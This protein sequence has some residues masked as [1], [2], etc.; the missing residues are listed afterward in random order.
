MNTKHI[1]GITAVAIVISTCI[2]FGQ[3]KP[4]TKK[5]AEEPLTKLVEKHFAQW[6]RN[7]NDV[8]DLMEVDH[9]IEDHNVH[10]RQ[11]AFVVSLRRHITGENNPAT[12]AHK[13]VLK[14]ADDRDFIKSV[15]RLAK[16][17]DLI[18]RE[19]FLAKDP[20][21][22]TFNQGKLNDCYY[23][24]PVAAL[25][26][27]SPKTIRSMIHPEV[28]GGFQVVYGDGQKIHVSPLTEGELLLGARLNEKH[29]SWLAVLEKSY[30]VIRKR[31]RAK[32][33][34]KPGNETGSEV[35]ATLNWGDSNPI[36]ALLTGHHAESVKLDKN[37]TNEKLH[38]LLTE[39][40]QK[41][42]LMC[43]G[44]NKD[45]G[46]P[47]IATNH[48]YAVLGY[49]SQARQVNVFNP[50]GNNFNP[51]GA[52]GKANGYSTKNGHF[53]VPLDEF[54]SVFSNLIYETD[55]PLNK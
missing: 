28:T 38:N 35:F 39:M 55:K 16:Q 32:K 37:I 19:L 41:K 21:L 11:A 27:R 13:D 3:S 17:L 29:G 46:P 34:D 5:T 1:T 54:H 18:D 31:D 43:V 49:E 8:I 44:K 24:S 33:I 6:D 26:N 20:D 42:R 15:D 40:S 47:G 45:K 22:T 52:S 53:T 14:L 9:A 7:H 4:Q 36:I 25:A 50:W 2:A 12:I 51:K 30:G 48:V 10:G 23:L